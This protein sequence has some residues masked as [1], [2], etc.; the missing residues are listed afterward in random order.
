MQKLKKI[1]L[2]LQSAV[3]KIG[4]SL[5]FKLIISLIILI[6]NLYDILDNTTKFRKEHLLLAFGLFLFVKYLKDLFDKILAVQEE[7]E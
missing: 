2:P 3:I 1:Y 5:Y 7:M 6:P 4:T